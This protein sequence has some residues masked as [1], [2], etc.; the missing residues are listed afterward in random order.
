MTRTKW[1]ALSLGHSMSEIVGLL[2]K[3]QFFRGKASGLELI[4]VQRNRIR[5]KFI[6]EIVTN[7]LVIDPFGEEIL[8][9]V[10]RY[11]IF[12]FQITP[13][14]KKQFLIRINNPPRSLKNFIGILSDAFGFGF[15][16]ESPSIDI[17]AM[18]QYLRKLGSI[19]RLTIRK[20]RMANIALS[21][22]SIAKIEVVSDVDAYQDLQK[23]MDIKKATLERATV[24][25]KD[26]GMTGEIELVSTGVI[27]G[28]IDV[29][30]RLMPAF[31]A[32]FS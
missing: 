27:S 16:I 13:L 5:G 9:K 11:S 19:K 29:L 2:E 4:D 20:V 18:L 10:R 30:D 8:N 28:D 14:A 22:S 7:E 1:L 3:Q 17:I 23:S 21:G 31:Q 32:Y 6:E 12:E 24:V 26:E 25:F 15:A